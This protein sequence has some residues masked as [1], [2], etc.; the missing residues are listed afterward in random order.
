M[1]KNQKYILVGVA[2]LISSM[3]LF[4]PYYF[5]RFNN[6]VSGS[7]YGFLFDIPFTA[8]VDIE[9]LIVQ[10]LGVIVVGI[11]LFFVAKDQ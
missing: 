8:S 1:N 9:K 5:T 7:G 4:P 11:I 2:I 6:T 10:W 3:L